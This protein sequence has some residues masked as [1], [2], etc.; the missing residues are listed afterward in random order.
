MKI[1]NEK[2][3]KAALEAHQSGDLVN[4][5]SLYRKFL[6]D[7][8]PHEA[9]NCNLGLLLLTTGRAREAIP[10][11][12][13]LI[14]LYPKHDHAHI[15]LANSYAQLQLFPEAL[16]RYAKAV[17]IAPE[18]SLG[19]YNYG[20]CWIDVGNYQ[21]ALKCF[22]VAIEKEP[23]NFKTWVNQGLAL[24]QLGSHEAALASFDRALKISPRFVEAWCNKAVVLT[25]LLRLDEAVEAARQ[26]ISIQPNSALAYSTLGNALKDLGFIEE[27]IAAFQF[28]ITLDPSDIKTHSKLAYSAYFH[29]GFSE[30]AILGEARNWGKLHGRV[31]SVPLDTGRD[32]NPHKRLRIGYVSPDF[33]EHCQSF[34]TLP[35][36]ANHDHREFEIFCY[37]SVGKPDAVTEKLSS[38]AD[39]WRT[40]QAENDQPLAETIRK[41]GID[42]LVDLTMHMAGGRPQLFNERPAP[43]QIAWLAYPGTTGHPAIDFRLT[44]PRLDPPEMPDNRYTEQSV[45]LPDTFW[46]YD[47]RE[48]R[49]QVNDLPAKQNGWLTFGCLNN[50]CKVTDMTLILWSKVLNAL[51]TARLLLL[52]PPTTYRSR[53]LDVLGKQGVSSERIEFV[54]YQSRD[55]YLDTYQRIDI[56]LDTIPYNGHTT[57]LDAYWMG[58]PVITLV[59]DTIVGRA[60]WSQLNN[61]SLTELAAFDEES[62][63]GIAK[64]F[65]ADL[66]RLGTLRATLRGRL[67]ASPLMDGKRF[68]RNMEA[69]FRGLWQNWTSARQE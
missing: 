42:V 27:A 60:G 36:L 34:F 38:L 56:C 1:R 35:L 4:A 11:F 20:K 15:Y 7:N 52:A 49:T 61:L 16:E 28:A 10:S 3:F 32:V 48:S 51:P 46:C 50:F 58:V 67:Q 9:A 68:A 37:S 26:A 30:T 66:E 8:P 44:D 2:T 12:Q 39:V 47:P 19:W 63:I 31:P 54:G 6:R 24:H 55:A 5:E 25:T 45:R 64:E 33:R 57:S 18:L 40:C 62:F 43:I 14:A 65:A 59:G 13:K 29:P 53:V 23:D 22:G 17:A 21:E 41:D 69:V